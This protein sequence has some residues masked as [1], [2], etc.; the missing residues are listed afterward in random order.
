MGCAPKPKI[1][2]ATA[3][4]AGVQVSVV[5][6]QLQPCHRHEQGRGLPGIR[7]RRQSG[8]LAQ[9]RHR[10]RRSS[11]RNGRS[12]SSGVASSAGLRPRGAPGIDTYGRLGGRNAQWQRSYSSSR[13]ADL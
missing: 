13:Q 11:S 4:G 12:C 7:A 6:V 3:K 9:R 5:W 10:R 8:L 1:Q 2:P